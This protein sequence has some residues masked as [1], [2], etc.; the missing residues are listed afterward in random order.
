MLYWGSYPLRGRT[1]DARLQLD[2]ALERNALLLS[3]VQQQAVVGV[4]GRPVVSIYVNISGGH[5]PGGDRCAG[6]INVT[7][8]A[9]R[10]LETQLSDEGREQLHAGF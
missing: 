9:Y 6:I 10:E 7:L 3:R 5:K 2:V 1:S 4:A 8:H